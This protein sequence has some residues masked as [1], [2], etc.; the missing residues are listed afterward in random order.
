MLKNR[1]PQPAGFSG[2]TMAKRIR[3][4][5]ENSGKSLRTVA[6]AAGID[7]GV[8]SRL[9]TKDTTEPRLVT[10][11]SLANYFQV[12][13]DWISGRSREKGEEGEAGRALWNEWKRLTADQ[14]EDVIRYARRLGVRRG[15]KAA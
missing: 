4:L 14:Q 12:S 13:L 7:A 9:A 15:K 8:L 11:W 1:A 3:A 10:L 2:S 6:E 5:I